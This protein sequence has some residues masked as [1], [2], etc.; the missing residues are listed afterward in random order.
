MATLLPDDKK[1]AL[2]ELD[3]QEPYTSMDLMAVVAAYNEPTVTEYSRVPI[4]EIQ[5]LL[6]ASDE[7]FGI[8]DASI[9]DPLCRRAFA[10]LT[11]RFEDIDVHH[12]RVQQVLSGLVSDGHIST[13]SKAMIDALGVVMRTPGQTI[14]IQ[15][16][17]VGH[18]KE[19]R[20]P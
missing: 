6:M 11:A 2:R 20:T 16:V 1:A 12:A 10:M 9:S 5:R 18:V 7:W 13:N 4:S 3:S 14:G 8:E 15:K 19:A 17:R